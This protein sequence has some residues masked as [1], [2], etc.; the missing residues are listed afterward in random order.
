MGYVS[1]LSV[2]MAAPHGRAGPGTWGQEN[3][4]GFLDFISAMMSRGDPPAIPKTA[5]AHDGLGKSAEPHMAIWQAHRLD[6]APPADNAAAPP[7]TDVE[8]VVTPRFAGSQED[9]LRL[10]ALLLGEEEN[11]G[12]LFALMQYISKNPG[13]LS[14]LEALSPGGDG[15]AKLVSL[16]NLLPLLVKALPEEDLPPELLPLEALSLMFSPPPDTAEADSPD[17]TEAIS[18][19]AQ[20]SGTEAAAQPGSDPPIPARQAETGSAQPAAIENKPL[21]TAQPEP[22][23]IEAETVKPA[24]ETPEPPD[25]ARTDEVKAETVKTTEAAEPAA[26]KAPAPIQASIQ[27]RE[28][29]D[30]VRVTEIKIIPP[31]RIT[32]TNPFSAVRSAHI[33]AAP[34]AIL[35]EALE[36]TAEPEDSPIPVS[37]TEGA[38]VWDLTEEESETPA[39]SVLPRGPT[40]R[41]EEDPDRPVKADTEPAQPLAPPPVSAQPTA[42]TAETAPAR[43]VLAARII[44]QITSQTTA[45][46]DVSMLQM[47]LN[48]KFLGKIQLVI[49]STAEG[50]TA[51]LKSDN[52]AVRSLLNEHI[53]DLRNSLK[54]A[55]INMRDIEVTESRIGTELSDRRREQRGTETAGES[56]SKVGGISAVTA[57]RE[58]EAGE[59][60]RAAY[61]TGRV[62]GAE[63]QFDYRA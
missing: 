2:S 33:T 12:F 40:E 39:L 7:D 21:E 1:A 41:P 28:L 17:L 27:G 29:P 56:K 15:E 46:K 9:L 34:A 43:Q 16:L 13:L 14:H 42:P 49:E 61:T 18:A 38:T 52:G 32:Y 62:S 24:P 54:E 30:A 4:G 25:T 36:Q 44:D 6:A 19:D 47:E 45:A 22:P 35:P 59:P 51:K 11:D 60:V 20:P 58:P 37:E 31:R 57:S 53:A 26:P 10:I 5:I 50:I 3:E 8:H 23:R 48:P 55:G 63:S